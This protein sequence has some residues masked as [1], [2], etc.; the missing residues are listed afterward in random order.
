[1]KRL[2]LLRLRRQSRL[3]EGSKKEGGTSHITGEIHCH[4]DNDYGRMKY[5]QMLEY[6]P[7]TNHVTYGVSHSA[8]EYLG[9]EDINEKLV[10]DSF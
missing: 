9:H 6:V 3:D 5:N 2:L 10:E 7:N 1:M 8:S 4:I